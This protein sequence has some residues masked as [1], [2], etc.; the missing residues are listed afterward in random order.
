MIQKFAN[1]T[2]LFYAPRHA[3]PGRIKAICAWCIRAARWIAWKSDQP[4]SGAMMCL[5]G[6]VM[7]LIGWP[8]L[9]YCYFA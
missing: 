6:A 9:I 1:T 8:L 4:M 5:C 2:P 3:A 7:G